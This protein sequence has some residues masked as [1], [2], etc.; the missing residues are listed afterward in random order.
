V[1]ALEPAAAELPDQH[2][3]AGSAGDRPG[4]V[5]LP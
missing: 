1:A 3:G 2:E 4:A 5:T